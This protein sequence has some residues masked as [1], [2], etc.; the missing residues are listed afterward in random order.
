M[1]SFRLP[2]AF[3]ALLSQSVAAFAHYGPPHVHGD[4]RWLLVTFVVC[5]GLGSL[6]Y[7]ISRLRR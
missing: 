1:N 6:A 7:V 3:A 2:L 5:V 4:D